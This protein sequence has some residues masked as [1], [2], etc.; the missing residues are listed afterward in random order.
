M[1]ADT[2]TSTVPDRGY[3]RHLRFSA[4]IVPPEQL[5]LALWI[6]A[7]RLATGLDLVAEKGAEDELDKSR[8]AAHPRPLAGKDVT[9]FKQKPR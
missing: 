4:Q 2:D 5:E 7:R 9:R 6:E 8:R 3:E 1:G